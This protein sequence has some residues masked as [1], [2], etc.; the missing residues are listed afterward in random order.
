M[1][2]NTI[3][4]ESDELKQKCIEI[5]NSHIQGINGLAAIIDGGDYNRVEIKQILINCTTTIGSINQMVASLMS[6]HLDPK[7]RIVES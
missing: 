6:V 2:Y 4:I 5:I 1:E 7:K 3:K